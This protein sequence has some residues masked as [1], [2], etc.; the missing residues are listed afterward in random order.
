MFLFIDASFEY[1][2]IALFTENKIIK[3]TSIKTNNNL[4]DL[5]V[6]HIVQ[7]IKGVKKSFHDLKR[8]YIVNG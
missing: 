7:L 6:E 5:I 1:L 8:L 3:S 2:N 4:T